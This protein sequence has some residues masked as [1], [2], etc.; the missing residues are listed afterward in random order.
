MPHIACPLSRRLS[1]LH[2]VVAE[3][4]AS[5][6][7]MQVMRQQKLDLKQSDEAKD[8]LTRISSIYQ[9]VGRKR[10]LSDVRVVC[11]C[12]VCACVFLCALVTSRN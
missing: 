3:M 11:V 8:I 2:S 5:I 6:E 10:V 9:R 4:D 7:R 12:Y 1:Q